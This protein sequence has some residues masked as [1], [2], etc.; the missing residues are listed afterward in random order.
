M[1][2]K[3][4]EKYN[5]WNAAHDY[6]YG[7]SHGF[8]SRGIAPSFLGSDSLPQGIADLHWALHGIQDNMDKLDGKMGTFNDNIAR[9]AN[10]MKN[11]VI[12]YLEDKL[13]N[14]DKN[15]N[16]PITTDTC[17]ISK[18]M[19]TR[20]RIFSD[21]FGPETPMPVSGRI[22]GLTKNYNWIQYTQ[23]N[24]TCEGEYDKIIDFN[25]VSDHQEND[26]V[27]SR[28]FTKGKIVLDKA[29]IVKR[30]FVTQKGVN[31]VLWYIVS[32][33]IPS[34]IG[35]GYTGSIKRVE[36]DKDANLVSDKWLP[37]NHTPLMLLGAFSGDS[38][39]ET[40]F[41]Q[42]IS[43]DYKLY[44]H[45]DGVDEEIGHL[46]TELIMLIDPLNDVVS[47][48]KQAYIMKYNTEGKLIMP[49]KA[50]TLIDMFSSGKVIEKFS[51][52]D[53][54]N[55][56]KL[57]TSFVS[58]SP[59]TET[60]LS[61]PFR[62]ENIVTIEGGYH[63]ELYDNNETY[64]N[65]PHSH[66]FLLS[67]TREIRDLDMMAPSM[68][69]YHS[70][71]PSEFSMKRER[72]YTE[73]NQI[74][75]KS[76]LNRMFPEISSDFGIPNDIP[77]TLETDW[78]DQ[79]ERVTIWLPEPFILERYLSDREVNS[80]LGYTVTHNS[81]NLID[82]AELN[83]LAVYNNLDFTMSSTV[84]KNYLSI[85]PR[86][87]PEFTLP[88]FTRYKVIKPSDNEQSTG[89][90]TVTHF[91]EHVNYDVTFE[92]SSKNL[93]GNINFNENYTSRH[94]DGLTPVTNSN[95]ISKLVDTSYVKVN[96]YMHADKPYD[97]DKYSFSNL[98]LSD[99]VFQIL[100][101]TKE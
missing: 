93:I 3:D 99:K 98:Q 31:I 97:S 28:H 96:R 49:M 39:N 30:V 87:N 51:L 48:S 76:G 26:K 42:Y 57:F 54:D 44:Q 101:S 24:P 59:R 52:I 6:G 67:S 91:D 64:P 71:A 41:S 7:W 94:E 86:Y 79:K 38:N 84:S 73:F 78:N 72:D 45:I 29:G 20:T 80:R 25:F 100:Y 81:D 12:E 22:R 70:D 68:M 55:Q 2:N 33:S 89:I 88:M 85:H 35:V 74:T 61:R 40:E 43:T 23:K 66:I 63:V 27:D 11:D 58:I 37:V 17:Y 92:T 1:P 77:F 53:F 21:S 75:F 50:F 60:T 18:V 14:K 69:N 46:P 19:T 56:N 9:I 47:D 32:Q 4:N 8:Q 83:V 82:K 90:T 16:S 62:K 13:I 95:N 10:D 36:Y 65:T 15:A 5:W 34:E